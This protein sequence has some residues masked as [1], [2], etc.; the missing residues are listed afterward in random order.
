MNNY[1]IYDEIASNKETGK[2]VYKARQKKSTQYVAVKSVEKRHKDIILNEVSVM[3]ALDHPNI[4]KFLNWYETSKHIWLIVEYCAGGSLDS[5]LEQD[6]RLPE[7][8]ILQ[9][10]SDTISALYCLHL[11]GFIHC[12]ISPSSFLVNDYGQIK[13]CGFSFARPIPTAIFVS[14][15]SPSP[16]SLPSSSMNS[17]SSSMTSPTSSFSSGQL[18]SSFLFSSLSARGIHFTT[19]SSSS[20]SSSFCSSS[21]HSSSSLPSS[22][23]YMAPE[24]FDS[25]GFYSFAS[26]FWSLGCVLYEMAFGAPPFVANT[27]DD[28]LIQLKGTKKKKSH[29]TRNENSRTLRITTPSPSSSKSILSEQQQQ[30][31]AETEAEDDAW[32]QL[33]YLNSLSSSSNSFSSCTSSSCSLSSSSSTNNANLSSLSS[34][35]SSPLSFSSSSPSIL[36]STPSFTYS[37]C[38]LSLLRRLLTRSPVHRITWTELLSH[39]I[40]SLTNWESCLIRDKLGL[41]PLPSSSSASRL[42][43]QPLI[44]QLYKNQKEHMHSSSRASPS[45]SPSS[46]SSSSNSSCSSSSSSQNCF[47]SAASNSSFNVKSSA[48]VVSNLSTQASFPSTS[49]SHDQSL[50]KSSPSSSSSRSNYSTAAVHVTDT[51]TTTD[52]DEDV[53]DDL[54]DLDI[55]SH[56]AGLRFSD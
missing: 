12:N 14:S 54:E 29:D 18:R 6:K 26:D 28:L 27:I 46:L 9:F 49:L 2:I 38:F 51:A 34:S 53:E 20:S 41:M 43:S 23:V 37:S 50:S 22:F 30:Y 17:S 32:C 19:P 5:L 36:S 48:S 45:S 10:A 16:S 21:S 8:T 13:L 33:P 3:H 35:S 47:V 1:H 52:D 25:D 42:P 40:W 39:S 4:L 56:L 11:N 15:S 24:L 7:T 31:E 44:Q 55:D